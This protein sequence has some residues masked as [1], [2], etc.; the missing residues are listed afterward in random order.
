MYVYR[1]YRRGGGEWKLSCFVCVERRGKTRPSRAAQLQCM[2]H[3]SEINR[4]FIEQLFRGA[5]S[6][7]TSTR[8]RLRAEREREREC[9]AKMLLGRVLQRNATPAGCTGDYRGTDI[10]RAGW[11][12]LPLGRATTRYFSTLSI[13]STTCSGE[14][15]IVGLGIL[16]I[17]EFRPE[18][19]LDREGGIN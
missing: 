7:S 16:G 13:K 6:A 3:K 2:E 15:S 11:L 19:R 14:A 17:F 8:Y 12:R 18:I 1:I 9:G 4:M 5:I 10:T